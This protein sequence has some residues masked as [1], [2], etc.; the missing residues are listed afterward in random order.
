MI[1]NV[2]AS[3][4]IILGMAF[5]SV[6][7]ATVLSTP[8]RAACTDTV[9]MIPA[10]YKGMQDGSCNFKA[11]E[12]NGKPD[13][14]QL[15]LKIALNVI[16]A[17]LVVVAYVTIFFIIKGGFGYI[18]AAGSP[19]GMSSAKKTITNALIGMVISLLAA[20]IVNAVAG[21]IK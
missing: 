8:A 1:R 5:T 20:S 15:I 18:T 16:Q 21:V 13:I 6:G 10:W 19:E 9:F 4:I 2:F 7:T 11:P 14:G 3:V 12:S 17:L